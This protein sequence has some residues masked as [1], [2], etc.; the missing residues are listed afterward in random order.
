MVWKKDGCWRPCGYYRR[1][2][3]VTIPDWYPLPNILDFTSCL[4]NSS[5]FSKLDPQKGYYQVPMSASD[6]QRTS[7]ITPFGMLEFLRLSFGL[8]NADQTFQE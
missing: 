6:I 8:R 1:L 2:N 5:V 3:N 4:D 7:I